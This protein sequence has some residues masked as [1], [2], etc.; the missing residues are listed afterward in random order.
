MPRIAIASGKGGVGKS[1]VSANL[2]AALADYGYSVALVDADIEGATQSLLFGVEVTEGTTLHDYLAGKA[3][4]D[5]VVHK[6]ANG[7]SAVFGSMQLE[8]LM[9]PLELERLTRLT[10]WLGERHEYVLIDSP[11]GFERDILATI[12]ASDALLI[13]LTPD[14]LSVTG[15]LKTKKV[16]RDEGRAVLGLVVNRSG[17]DHDIPRNELEALMDERVLATIP[18]V[19]DVRDSVM[20]GVPIVL[21]LPKHE[22]SKAIKKLA[23]KVISQCKSLALVA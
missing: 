12:S 5:E 10:S 6:V 23:K 20:A 21:S 22:V 13:V 17:H 14:I 1:M 15:A 4:E 2:A 9:E 19:P 7:I 16:A 8:A 3:S 18:D 11:P